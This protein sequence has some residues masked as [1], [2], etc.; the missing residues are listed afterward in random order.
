MIKDTM[1]DDIKIADTYSYT[2]SKDI[3][4]FANL[5]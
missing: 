3:L 1:I 5:H 2:A 4:L